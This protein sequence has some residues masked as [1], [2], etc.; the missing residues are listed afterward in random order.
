MH[1]TTGTPPRFEDWN[2]KVEAEVRGGLARLRTPLIEGFSVEPLYASDAEACLGPKLRADLPRGWD[3]RARV[4]QP[5]PGEANRVALDELAHDAR[6]VLIEVDAQ[7]AAGV[8]LRSADDLRRVLAGIAL[9]AAP[10]ALGQ[11]GFDLELARALAQEARGG[12]PGLELGLDPLGALA[13]TGALAGGVDAAQAGALELVDAVPGGRAL[14]IDA[15]V[16]HHAGAH[17]AQDLG[18]T[19]AGAL[20]WLRA[21]DAR[22]ADLSAVWA[23][24]ALRVAV[25][26]EIFLAMA[27]LRALRA[28]WARLGEVMGLDGLADIT[29][30]PSARGLTRRD[31]WVNIL[32]VTATTVAGALGGAD[33]IVTVAFD[34]AAGLPDDAGRRLARNTQHVLGLES[35]LG[36]VKDPAGGSYYIEALT[37]Q[38]AAAGWSFFQEVEREGGLAE[39]LR[40]G[41]VQARVAESAQRRAASVSKRQRPILGVSEFPDPH[42]RRPPVRPRAVSPRP[43][44]PVGEAGD[45]A[46]PL[47]LR[48][49]AEPFEALRDRAEASGAPRVFLACLG[50]LAEHGARA[51]FV[52]PLAQAGGFES[53]GED[54]LGSLDDLAAAFAASGA[55]VACVC[56]TDA[57]Y[58]E[59]VEPLTSALRAAGAT[60]VWVAGRPGAHEAAW[61]A[62]GVT[63]FVYVGCDALAALGAW[64]KEQA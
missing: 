44:E 55:R 62:A 49:L 63:G 52:R 48:R 25:D 17:E 30:R 15:W 45:R 51:G 37:A 4:H 60:Q 58:A 42:E 8:A 38:L 32:R 61:R 14:A 13:R 64:W 6:S 56:G 16:W 11:H 29:V 34:D 23:S 53:V 41:W 40:G 5:D 3:L 1:T 24:L 35:H 57:Q 46:E 9:D 59:A 36:R 33:H 21:A 20:A 2:A 7:G 19:L 12:A 18:L 26:S 39:A 31:P 43:D 54:Q 28:L 47:P 10:V 27:K 22:G 50:G